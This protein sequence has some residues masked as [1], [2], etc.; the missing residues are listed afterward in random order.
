LSNAD[1]ESYSYSIDG[2]TL[3]LTTYKPSK[4]PLIIT[5][6]YGLNSISAR[7]KITGY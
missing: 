6:S 3:T 5:A 2:N 7:I 1:E 4:N